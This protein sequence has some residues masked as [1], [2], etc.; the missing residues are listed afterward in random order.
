[1]MLSNDLRAG[2]EKFFSNGR[3]LFD[4]QFVSEARIAATIGEEH[5]DFGEA[6]RLPV[7][8]SPVAEIRIRRA[9][10]HAAEPPEPPCGAREW[11]TVRKAP[12]RQRRSV[13]FVE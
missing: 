8:L 2:L 7:Q 1:V 12:R 3:Q 10:P 5:C 13:N 4:P 11:H 9:A 6:A